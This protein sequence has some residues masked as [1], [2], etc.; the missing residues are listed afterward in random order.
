MQYGIELNPYKRTKDQTKQKKEETINFRYAVELIAYFFSCLFISR[1]MLLNLTAPF[2]V[3]FLMAILN[4]KK[5]KCAMCAALGTFAG[6]LT[7]IKNINNVP[8]YFAI[9]LS[10]LLIYIFGEKL[11]N[12]YKVRFTIATLLVILIEF[13]GYYIFM[14]E[15]STVVSFF[16]SIVQIACIFPVYYI[17]N[18]AITCIKEMNINHIYSNEEIIS[19]I[20]CISFIVSGTWGIDVYGVSVRNIIAMILVLLLG[21]VNGATVGA[22]CGV[23]VGCIMGITS[24]NILI[25]VSIYSLCGLITGLF[26]ETGKVISFCAYAV[27]SFILIIYCKTS[28]HFKAIEAIASGM[29][30]VVIPANY[31]KKYMLEFETNK[32]H[33]Q[34]NTFYTEKTKELVI[35]KIQKYAEVIDD[36]HSILRKLNFKNEDYL[37]DRNNVILEK[38]ARRVC[39]DCDMKDVCWRRE[40]VKTNKAFLELIENF[41][42]NVKI[43]PY[44][45]ER[46]CVK[47]TS[48]LSNS[49]NIVNNFIVGE[50]WRNHIGD[51]GKTILNGL[52]KISI[53]IDDL[54][55][56]VRLSYKSD[57][58]LDFKVRAALNKECI[59]FDNVLCV[60][61]E[62]CRIM[63]KL[64]IKACGGRK[65]CTKDILPVINNVTKEKMCVSND[66]CDINTTEGTCI[67][68]FKQVPKYHIVSSA[69][70]KCKDGET[71]CGDSYYYDKLENDKYF[72][73][74]SDGMGCGDD[75]AKESDSVLKLTKSLINS[76]IPKLRAVEMINSIMAIKFSEEERF[77]TIDL[78]SIDLFTGDSEFIKIG[79]AVSYIKSGDNVISISAKTLP[80]GVLDK[81]DYD[82][83][84]RKL[85]D[86]DIL[87]MI[88]DGMLDYGINDEEGDWVRDF[89]EKT[90]LINPDSISNEIMKKAKKI[91]K[92]KIKDDMT[93]IVSRIYNI[94]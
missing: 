55:S 2:G 76:G 40:M 61:D 1:V 5:G 14:K 22:S 81:A 20:V 7:L 56:D 35:E 72:I 11:R 80:I 28:P 87:V 43:L 69:Q 26:R 3:A 37:K 36:M 84:K 59:D 86:G 94:A 15:T 48:L 12:I 17:L 62:N 42:D 13:T 45:I 93:V 68:T 32:N 8:V 88:S 63:I 66:E 6:Y 53:S 52:N 82:I 89:L 49:E 9:T 16:T 30:F 71:K 78:S 50:M 64:Y 91:S 75:A 34:I 70:F 21:Y 77:S 83:T 44:E 23:A 65:Y 46:K 51:D 39:F 25:Y 54:I 90:Q 27:C 58:N 33:A 73:A 4:N 92:S 38:L 19:I 24:S 41:E 67:I 29:A 47:R 31:L 60:Y 85:K 74:L 57:T 79:A 18:E 10:V